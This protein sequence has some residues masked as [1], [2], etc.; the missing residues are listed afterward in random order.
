M[1]EFKP[2]FEGGK[3]LQWI[4]HELQSLSTP[5]ASANAAKAR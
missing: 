4:E 5:A 3:N 2:A 1:D